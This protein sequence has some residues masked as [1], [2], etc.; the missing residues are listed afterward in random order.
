MKIIC[1]E[2]P[3]TT[4]KKLIDA[5]IREYSESGRSIK[6]EITPDKIILYFIQEMD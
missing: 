2:L 3:K 6:T 5:H 4:D 1:K